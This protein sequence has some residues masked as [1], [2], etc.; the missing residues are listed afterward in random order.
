[1]LRYAQLFLG[2]RLWTNIPDFS[3][4]MNCQVEAEIGKTVA[5]V[6]FNGDLTLAFGEHIGGEESLSTLYD[7]LYRDQ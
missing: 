5:G 2:L 7:H 6:T 3:S 4:F 1:M